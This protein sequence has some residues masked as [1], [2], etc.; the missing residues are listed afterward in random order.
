MDTDNEF[1]KS[2]KRAIKA[3]ERHYSNF[4]YWMNFYA[5]IIGSLFVGYYTIKEDELLKTIV[6][7]IGFATTLAWL[8]SFRGYY[9]WIKQWMNVVM[10]HEAQYIKST[11]HNENEKESNRVYSLYYES[12][13]EDLRC[14]LK[15]QNIST[16]KMTLRL[17]F[18]LL[19][20]WLILLVYNSCSLI[21][22]HL[23]TVCE[24]NCQCGCLCSLPRYLLITIML[25]LLAG[26]LITIICLFCFCKDIE[27]DVPHHYRLKGHND[28][29]H[30]EP[31]KD[32]N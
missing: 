28:D 22:I 11:G 7:F 3:R 15:T 19:L 6:T 24:K 2:Y 31:P 1:E 16:Q 13:K 14:P 26:M 32:N 5:I 20:S 9:H 25:I 8:Q 17:I 23:C 21:G 10:F 18:V 27:S 4:N 29:Y 12:A 30:I